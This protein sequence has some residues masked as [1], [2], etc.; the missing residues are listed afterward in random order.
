MSETQNPALPVGSIILVTGVNGFIGSHV[1]DQILAAGYKVRGTVRDAKK[2]AWLSEFFDSRYG[3]DKFELVEI[4]D[5]S[6]SGALDET[7][8]GTMPRNPL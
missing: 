2:N 3:K 1:G 6:A 8:K 7:L 5:L 4:A